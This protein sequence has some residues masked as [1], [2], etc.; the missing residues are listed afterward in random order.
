MP[1]LSINSKSGV[2]A[3]CTYWSCNGPDPVKR[4][5]STFYSYEPNVVGQCYLT[6]K[7]TKSNF[8]CPKYSCKF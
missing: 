5:S 2:C 3:Y 4:S 8:T 7:K 6:N 1:G